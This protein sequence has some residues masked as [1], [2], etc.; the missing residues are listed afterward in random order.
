M[1]PVQ[2]QTLKRPHNV[3]RRVRVLHGRGCTVGKKYN[4]ALWVTAFALIAS[5]CVMAIP[6]VVAPSSA[7]AAP[8]NLANEQG[9]LWSCSFNPFVS[10]SSPYSVGLTYETLDFVDSLQRGKVTPWL[11][12]AYAWSNDNETLTFTI[13]PGVAWSDGKP[14]SAA[15]VVYTFNL[16]KKFP[17]LD[18]NAVWSALS[19]VAR[20]G[21]NQVVFNFSTPA[22]SYFYYIAGQVPIVPEHIWSKIKNPV[23]NPIS[24]PVGT[25][26]YLMS[27]CTP[28]NIQWTANANYWQKGKAQVETV[29]ML[30]F[31]TNDTANEY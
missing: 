14:F 24:N 28:E 4:G 11:A 6:A 1:T 5:T 29:N 18:V 25:G 21:S 10:T 13:R 7:G 16:L 22:V 31:L 19:S 2:R 12:T 17:A 3:G 23:A 15:D 26:G 30:A 27:N 20:K 8:L 9:E